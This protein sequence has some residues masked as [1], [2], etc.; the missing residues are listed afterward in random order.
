MYFSLDTQ[1]S[2]KKYHH[3]EVLYDNNET[4]TIICGMHDQVYHF[5]L[6]IEN[7]SSQYY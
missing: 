1:K 6:N 2:L 5:F 4:S 3:E 7:I